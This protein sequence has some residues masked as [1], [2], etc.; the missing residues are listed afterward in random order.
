MA[1]SDLF[2]NLG[3]GKILL[4]HGQKRVHTIKFQSVVAPNG[5]IANLFGPVEGRRHDSSM[6]CD[7]DLILIHLM[8]IHCVFTEIWHI[9]CGHNYKHPLEITPNSPAAGF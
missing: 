3:L 9:P 8:E 5:L 4:H 1:Q 6:L 2:V 7:S